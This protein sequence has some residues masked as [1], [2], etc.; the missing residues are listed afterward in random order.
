MCICAIVTHSAFNDQIM[1]VL[2]LSSPLI[3]DFMAG[4]FTLMTDTDMIH[5]MVTKVEE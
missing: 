5:E 2:I 1:D 4:L 3:L